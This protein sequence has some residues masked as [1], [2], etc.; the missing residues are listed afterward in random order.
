MLCRIGD[1]SDTNTKVYGDGSAVLFYYKGLVPSPK[2]IT[3]TT[4]TKS[5]TQ[6]KKKPVKKKA[7]KI[8]AKIEDVG[9]TEKVRKQDVVPNFHDKIHI[10]FFFNLSFQSLLVCPVSHYHKKNG[11]IYVL[12]T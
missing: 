12:I 3:T 6:T 5:N 11:I 2:N 4:T 1:I 7:F 8:N 10:A 9:L